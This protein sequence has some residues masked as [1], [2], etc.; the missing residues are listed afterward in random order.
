MASA[1]M[2]AQQLTADNTVLSPRQSGVMVMN[3]VQQFTKAARPVAKAPLKS[4]V[5]DGVYYARPT[6]TYWL[7]NPDRGTVYN[8]VPP[9]AK[10]SYINL[11][12]NAA[13]STWSVGNNDVT[14]LAVGDNLDLE[15]AFEKVPYGYVAYTPTLKNGKLDYSLANYTVV[16]DSVPMVV[17]P[18]EYV[19]GHRYYGYSDGSSA[20]MSGNDNYDFDGDGEAE[21]FHIHGFQTY[22]EKPAAPML[23]YDVY[24]LAT[25]AD[26]NTD[27]SKVCL[28][29]CKVDVNE[30]GYRVVGDTIT[31]L[32]CTKVDVDAEYIDK[33]E[34]YPLTM[35]FTAEEL[36][37]FGTPTAKPFLIDEDYW[38]ILDGIDDID[39]R[40]YFTNQ[41]AL[42][43][44]MATYARP[45]Y[46]MCE[47]MNHEAL[48]NLYY[49]D[50]KAA[51]PYCY[52]LAYMFDVMF[53][54]MRIE[55]NT[56]KVGVEGGQAQTEEAQTHAVWLYT[57]MPIYEDN[58]WTGNYEFVGI[59]EWAQLTIDP[60]FYEYTY[61]D[62]SSI[63][64]L[65][66]L[67]FEVQALPAGMTGRSA[68][69]TVESPEFN[70]TC[71]TPIYLLQG[72]AQVSEGVQAIIFDEKGRF[73]KTYNMNGQTV[74]ANAKGIVVKNG[75]KFISK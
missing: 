63:R 31:S 25:T 22:F 16:S 43:V 70:Y 45:T 60:T 49:Y 1:S 34:V 36:D 9:Y 27:F 71:E 8:V 35:Y 18:Y 59:P 24:L 32:Y 42:P 15:Y 66:L 44:E 50:S 37:D 68:T 53:D 52:N 11:S 65:N 29:F 47:D 10:L 23:F 30:E 54:G 33:T 55:N 19:N 14:D 40:F 5:T 7:G 69:I 58:E 17:Y 2:S 38:I 57:N 21:E 41:G 73:V 74:G 48:G 61:D 72:D 3:Q 64:G 28:R 67:S 51:D 4:P 39:V 26:R 13:N 6:G 62:G 12:D 75:H 20:F 46:I 56:A